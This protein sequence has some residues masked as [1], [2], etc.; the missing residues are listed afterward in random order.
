MVDTRDFIFGIYICSSPIY[1]HQ[2]FGIYG[3]HAKFVGYILFLAH[4]PL[5]WKLWYLENSDMSEFWY[6][7][8]SSMLKILIHWNSKTSGIPVCQKLYVGLLIILDLPEVPVNWNS[9]ALEFWYLRILI[10]LICQIFW[11]IGNSNMSVIPLCWDSN[12]SKTLEILMLNFWY[13]VIPMYWKLDVSEFVMYW[14][15]WH[16]RIATCL[17]IPVYQKSWCFGNSDMP[18]ISIHHKFWCN[19]IPIHL[20]SNMSETWYILFPVYQELC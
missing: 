17:E 13:I 20:D 10:F 2:I 14:N 11:Y 15:F 12:N 9:N 19:Q 3:I 8:N 1:G 16:I 5:H 6:I 4:I 7:R 18:E